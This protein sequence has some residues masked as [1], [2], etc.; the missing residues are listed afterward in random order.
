MEVSKFSRR[1]GHVNPSWKPEPAPGDQVRARTG[2]HVPIIF[3]V[4]SKVL[5]SVSYSCE[6]TAF[7]VNAV[8]CPRPNVKAMLWNAYE[9][10]GGTADH[11]LWHWPGWKF[12]K[13]GHQLMNTVIARSS[14]QKPWM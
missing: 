4:S 2:D 10:E 8:Q 7:L 1:L 12:D 3:G 11:F 13:H 14:Q 9:A 6:S 5:S